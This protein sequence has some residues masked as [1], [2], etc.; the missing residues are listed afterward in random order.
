MGHTTNGR[1]TGAAGTIL[2]ALAMLGAASTA[3]ADV[4]VFFATATPTPPLVATPSAGATGSRATGA[5]SAAPARAP[6]AS[7]PAASPLAASPAGSTARGPGHTRRSSEPVTSPAD[8]STRIARS[9][10]SEMRRTD[11]DVGLMP[12]RP[13]DQGH[14]GATATRSSGVVRHEPIDGTAPATDAVAT[15]P[16]TSSVGSSATPPS[17]AATSVAVTSGAVT[18]GAATSGAVTSGAAT[19]VPVAPELRA[20]PV[21]PRC[22]GPTRIVRAMDG[23]LETRELVLV[24]CD[25]APRPDALHELTLLARPRALRER[26]TEADLARHR[27]DAA[28]L[29]P[30]VHRLDPG[31]LPRLQYIASA[32]P[33]HTIELVSGYRPDAREGSRH[34]TGHA[35]DVRVQG[36]SLRAMHT[37]ALELEATGLGLYPE[38][39]FIHVDVRDR[40]TRWVD[41]AGPGERSNITETVVSRDGSRDATPPLAWRWP[42]TDSIDATEPAGS[43]TESTPPPTAPTEVVPAATND[44]S[45]AARP[46]RARSHRRSGSRRA[47]RP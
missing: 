18:S 24:D 12:I 15:T 35:L 28:F 34:R 23:H 40:V 47:P 20:R 36:V 26:P 8:T 3:E 19:S 4:T 46:P 31:I 37:R 30:D 21:E 1:R 6:A 27:D 41:L 5:A 25:G 9:A 32:F 42:E 13:S 14:I 2:G 16:T 29:A 22:P 17:A 39:G 10:R 7:P 45:N 11:A 44:A 38:S 43:S 33:G